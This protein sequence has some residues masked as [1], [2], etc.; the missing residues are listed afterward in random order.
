VLEIGCAE[1]AFGAH[2]RGAPEIW[3]I[4]P[5]AEAAG[6]AARRL[7]TVLVGTYERVRDRLPDRFF[8]LVICNDVIEHMPD[9]DAFLESIKPKLKA[10]AHLVGSIPNVRHVRTL[11]EL[12]VERDWRY[13]D[14]GV[15]DRTHLRFFTQKSLRRTFREHGYAVEALAGINSAL[16]GGFAPRALLRKAAV[17]AVIAG[18][19]GFYWDAQFAQFGFRVRCGE[20]S[21]R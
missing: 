14:A 4:E 16:G 2:L 7:A 1:G 20:L 9:H 21:G 19:L 5:A 13:A 3:G 11:Y 10:G 8:D 18:T 6:I 17:L 15:L 12:L